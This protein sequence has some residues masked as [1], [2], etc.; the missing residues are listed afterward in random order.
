MRDL[1]VISVQAAGVIRF[2]FVIRGGKDYL[3]YKERILFD[4]EYSFAHAKSLNDSLAGFNK[5]VCI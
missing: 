3:R 2:I 4:N 5:T 1:I